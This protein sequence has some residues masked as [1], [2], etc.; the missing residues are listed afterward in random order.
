VNA[1]SRDDDLRRERRFEMYSRISHQQ[2]QQ[3]QQRRQRRRRRRRRK[4]ELTRVG[5]THPI[6]SSF[7]RSRINVV[8]RLGLVRR[9]LEAGRVEFVLMWIDCADLWLQV[10]AGY[11]VR[12][13]VSG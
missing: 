12:S 4:G 13:N 8:R 3:Q 1:I 9:R 2:Q 11:A 6:I 10:Y 7:P 5:H